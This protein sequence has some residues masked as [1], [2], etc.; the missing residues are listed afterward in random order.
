MTRLLVIDDDA[1][2]AFALERFARSSGSEIRV[3][4]CAEEGLA[5][6]ARETFDLVLLD[7]GLPGMSGEEALPLLARR[8]LPVV[9]I[10]AHA[11]A[12]TA[13]RCRAAGAAHVLA[14]PFALAELRRV[15]QSV[16]AAPAA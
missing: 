16:L 12:D 11:S 6:L 15:I 7:L 2:V 1:G 14:K 5:L 4:S 8:G 3:V 10:S 13:A 9:V